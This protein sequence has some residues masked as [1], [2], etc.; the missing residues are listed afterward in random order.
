[1]NSLQTIPGTS[2]LFL[3]LFARRDMLV[4]ISSVPT[5]YLM[6]RTTHV[7]RLRVESENARTVSL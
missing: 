7:E 3:C 4:C 1:M 5:T 2:S 6:S